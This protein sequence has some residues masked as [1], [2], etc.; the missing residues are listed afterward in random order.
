[1]PDPR[2]WPIVKSEISQVLVGAASTL[3]M[4]ANRNRADAD[5]TVDDN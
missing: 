2:I 5:F 4:A 3:A 1:M